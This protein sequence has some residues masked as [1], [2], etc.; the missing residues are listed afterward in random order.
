MD[1]EEFGPMRLFALLTFLLAAAATA[2]DKR[3][4]TLEDIA[5][6]KQVTSAQL[7]P[8][9]DAIAYLLSVPRAPFEDEDG[10]AWRELHVWT[11]DRG[12]RPY[13]TGKTSIGSIQWTPDGKAIS[14]LAK[15]GDDEHTSVYVIPL[16]GGEARRL[17]THETSIQQH[18]WSPLGG[19]LSFLANPAPDKDKDKLAKKGFDQE[20]YEEEIDNTEVWIADISGDDPVKRKLA[21]DGSANDIKWAPD[22][23]TLAVQLSR[24][25]LV[26]DAYMN[27]KVHVI[28]AENGAQTLKIDNPGKLGMMRWSPDGKRLAMLAAADRNDPSAGRLYVTAVATGKVDKY[29]MEDEGDVSQFSW[30]DENTIMYLWDEGVYTSI[31]TLNLDQGGAELDQRFPNLPIQ[32]QSTAGGKAALVGSKPTHPRELFLWEEGM[33]EPQRLTNSN[34]WL[35]E[36]DLAPQEVVTY[37]ARDGLELQGLLIRPLDEK[38]GQRYPLILVVH[39]GPEAHYR[40]NWITDYARLGQAAAAQGYAVFYPNYRASTG[41]GVAFSKMDHARP[42][43]EEFDDLV[44]GVKHLVNIGLVDEKRVGVTGGSYGGYA[45]AW[46]ST[47]LS[48]HFAAGVMFVGISNK[49]S[50]AGTSDIPDELYLVHDRKRL[51]EDWNLFL[52][53]SPIYHVEKARTPLLILHGKKDTRVHPSQSMELYRHLKTIGKTPV[54]LVFYPKEGH[55][56]RRAAARYD[57]SLRAM[58]WFDHYLKGDGKGKPPTD[59]DYPL[60][61]QAKAAD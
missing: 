10:S 25:A 5:K 50:K 3:G 60:Q 39:G 14:F 15:R 42:A 18:E 54:R 37:Q 8:N 13:I 51:W 16:D 53:A 28:K 35:D 31:K 59:V 57:Y 55:G 41:R 22:G 2:A 49:I 11:P 17:L 7:S 56:N 9:G 43:A 26:D 45:T 36:V 38:K 40:H 44:D 34:P 23:K 27:T 21:L 1:E 32:S 4:L 12:S 46:C 58:R 20:I 19:E 47:A 52:N 6:L 29:F 61:E 24:T 30:R 48:E 33:A